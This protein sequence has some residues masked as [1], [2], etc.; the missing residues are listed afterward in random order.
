VKTA[1]APHC[2]RPIVIRLDLEDF[3]PSVTAGRVLNL[4]LTAGYPEPVARAL[5]RLCTQRVPWPIIEKRPPKTS[6]ASTQRL[7]ATH[8]PQGA[9]TS[10]ALANLAAFRLDSRLA[11][12]A[13]SADAAYTRYA[14][15]LIF[16][17]GGQLSRGA[18]RFVVTVAAIVLDCGFQ[19]AHR[20]TRLMR[21]G[22]CQ[23]AA[24]VVL[25]QHPNVSRVEF[26]RLKATLTNCLRHGAEGQN[27]EA[28]SDFRAHLAG[29]IAWL[30]SLNP[31]RGAKLRALF[32][33]ISWSS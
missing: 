27:R 29:R 18:E 21:R 19:V 4:F 31:R 15:D 1:V 13:A 10:P 24:G 32:E 7:R 17:G 28:H 2:D 30:E 9:P 11:S 33:R 12:L 22:V 8:L 23:R 16:S 26:D 14:D 3:F 5:T 25:N 6:R 20:K